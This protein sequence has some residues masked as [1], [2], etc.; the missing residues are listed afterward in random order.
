[1][2][3][4]SPGIAAMAAGGGAMADERQARGPSQQP[5]PPGLAAGPIPA[6]PAAARAEKPRDDFAER[7]SQDAF[8]PKLPES[9]VYILSGADDLVPILNPQGAGTVAGR[10]IF[11]VDYQIAYDRPRIES[12]WIYLRLIAAMPCSAAAS[13]RIP[14]PI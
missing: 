8:V 11:G 4:V 2:A 5:R 10:T 12:D 13:A 1:L 6:P 3:H 7:V 9:D 14:R